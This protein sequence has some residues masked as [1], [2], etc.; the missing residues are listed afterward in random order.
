VGK[1]EEGHSH[2]LERVH[3]DPIG[4]KLARYPC[5]VAVEVGNT[6]IILALVVDFVTNR[7]GD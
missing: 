5:L 6:F 7:E 3:L 1:E 2:S 4:W